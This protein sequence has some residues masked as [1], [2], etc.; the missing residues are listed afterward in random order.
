MWSTC[1]TCDGEGFLEGKQ[2][3]TYGM[4]M[5]I[6]CHICNPQKYILDNLMKGQVWVDDNFSPVSPPSSPR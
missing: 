5:K 1:H 3:N 2:K 4:W 6:P